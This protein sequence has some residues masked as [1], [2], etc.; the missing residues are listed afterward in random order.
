MIRGYNKDSKKLTTVISW[1][2]QKLNRTILK[3]L[4]ENGSTFQ[5][6]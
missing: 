1:L 6:E 5:F 4:Y 2:K 3:N